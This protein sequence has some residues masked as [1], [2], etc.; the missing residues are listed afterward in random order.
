MSDK[1]SSETKNPEQTNKQTNDECIQ[2]SISGWNFKYVQRGNLKLSLQD[3]LKL[4]LMWQITLIYSGYSTG[5]IRRPLVNHVI[6]IKIVD[7]D[8]WLFL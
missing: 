5:F 2:S 4:S 7:N 8:T 3:V 6:K 1:F